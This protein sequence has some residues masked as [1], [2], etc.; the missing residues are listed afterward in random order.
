[1]NSMES[2]GGAANAQAVL[3]AIKQLPGSYKVVGERG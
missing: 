3:V 1:M 2:N